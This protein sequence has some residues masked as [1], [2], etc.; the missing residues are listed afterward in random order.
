MSALENIKP[1][2]IG[3]LGCNHGHARAY[4]WLSKSPYFKLLGVSIAHGYKA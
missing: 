2:K 4:Y 1:V 3:I